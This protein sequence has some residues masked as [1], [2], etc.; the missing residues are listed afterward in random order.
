MTKI[1][2]LNS[3]AEPTD[4]R[5]KCSLMFTLVLQWTFFGP[6]V[7]FS[8]WHTLFVC[9]TKI[10]CYIFNFLSPSQITRVPLIGP[11][12]SQLT[13]CTSCLLSSRVTECGWCDGRCTRADQCPSSSHW[14]QDYCTPVITK[15]TTA[16]MFLGYKYDAIV[17]ICHF[18]ANNLNFSINFAASCCHRLLG[19]ES[20][21]HVIRFEL[22][23]NS[24]SFL[25]LLKQLI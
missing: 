12:C 23:S 5:E 22:C 19:K 21:D 7:V 13:S 18:T 9:Q 17:R 16:I 25:S 20:C 1:F 3:F 2:L 6:L 15:V 4:K 10:K 24:L 8:V 14:T 11:G